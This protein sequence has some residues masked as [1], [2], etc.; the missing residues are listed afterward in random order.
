MEPVHTNSPV[1]ARAHDYIQE[2][3]RKRAQ[4]Q[5]TAGK[6]E[7]RTNEQHPNRVFFSQEA[8]IKLS[9]EK[10]HDVN[11]VEAVRVENKIKASEAYSQGIRQEIQKAAEIKAD[12]RKLRDERFRTAQAKKAEATRQFLASS[13]E[14]KESAE[15]IRKQRADETA[16]ALS[17]RAEAAKRMQERTN[18]A[19]ATRDVDMRIKETNRIAEKNDIATAEKN[20]DASKRQVVGTIERGRKL[21]AVTDH[22]RAETEKAVKMYNRVNKLT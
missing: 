2:V 4:E 21:R 18:A 12:D 16:K 20:I 22:T 11:R 1:I 17:D 7:N 15:F 10:S 3:K 6:T 9:E 13:K 8:Q 5:Q 19:V 14:I